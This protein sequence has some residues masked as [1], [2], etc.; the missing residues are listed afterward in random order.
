[1]LFLTALLTWTKDITEAARK[2]IS[3][4]A[5]VTASYV[6]LFL[7]I[8]RQHIMPISCFSNSK[9]FHRHYPRHPQH[10]QR[11]PSSHPSPPINPY[12]SEL[13]PSLH[14]WQLHHHSPRLQKGSS[15]SLSQLYHN[16]LATS[17]LDIR[18]HQRVWE[19]PRED[20]QRTGEMPKGHPHQQSEWQGSNHAA[21]LP[22][23]YR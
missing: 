2:K 21:T 4:A 17:I 7:T 8:L 22:L 11:P 16:N 20:S 14:R 18:E 5:M 9:Q 1:M 13:T 19:W 23:Q 15:K 10:T 6:V 12:A 3:I